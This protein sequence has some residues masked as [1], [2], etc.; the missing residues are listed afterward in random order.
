MRC[1]LPPPAFRMLDL[2]NCTS[3]DTLFDLGAGNG[4]VVS[5]P[6]DSCVLPFQMMT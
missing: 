5:V 6:Q 2:T 3:K 4:V 1:M